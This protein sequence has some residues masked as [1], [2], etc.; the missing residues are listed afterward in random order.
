VFSKSGRDGMA[1]LCSESF[2][3]GASNFDHELDTLALGP[4]R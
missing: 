4:H 1:H 2:E 3:W